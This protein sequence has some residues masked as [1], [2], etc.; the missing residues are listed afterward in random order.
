MS[1]SNW[2]A[3]D[4]ERLGSA[5][6]TLRDRTPA[7]AIAAPARSNGLRVGVAFF[8]FHYGYW[9]AGTADRTSRAPRTSSR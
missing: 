4:A 8:P 2:A 6:A 1:G 5:R 9:D 3:D 7:R